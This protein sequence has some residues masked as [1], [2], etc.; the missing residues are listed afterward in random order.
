M[1]PAASSW[2]PAVLY[3]SGGGVGH[4]WGRQG[5][6]GLVARLFVSSMASNC[7][8]SMR[9]GIVLTGHTLSSLLG[10]E[11]M[12]ATMPD[13]HSWELNHNL[14]HG[15]T[16]YMHWHAVPWWASTGWHPVLVGQAQH[17]PG[18]CLQLQDRGQCCSSI[19]LHG[20]AQ[21]V[22]CEECGVDTLPC[23]GWQKQQDATQLWYNTKTD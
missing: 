22:G 8:C 13:V 4:F 23:P 19:M 9:C 3:S 6:P 7:A 10:G 20:G 16:C 1:F 18:V 11:V 21:G 17:K 5:P 14:P 12:L 15:V 2:Q